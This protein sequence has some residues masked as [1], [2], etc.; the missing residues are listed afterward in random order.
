VGIKNILPVKPDVVVSGI[1]P[2]YNFGFSAYLSGTV[3]A[4]R[5]AVMEGVP[6][7]AASI[8]ANAA[9]RDYP[10]AAAQVVDVVRRIQATPLPPLTLLNVNIPAAPAGGY[11]GYQVTTPAPMRAGVESFA[12]T[13]HP[14][15]RTIYWSVYR[16]EFTPPEG[17]DG[18]AVAN[19]FVSVTPLRVGEFDA[20]TT[21]R[22]RAIFR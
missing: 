18:W 12:E 1:N 16:E 14:T 21:D 10:A 13:K 2:G 6:G 4:A 20:A 8:A 9:P 15:G 22:V 19:G 7:I 5:Q 11:K 17:S 3:G